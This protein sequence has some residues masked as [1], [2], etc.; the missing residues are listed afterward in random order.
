MRWH[1]LIRE[2][3]DK[4]GGNPALADE[5]PLIYVDSQRQQLHS[6]PPIGRNPIA[7]LIYIASHASC[8]SQNSE[9]CNLFHSKQ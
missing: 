5:R 7:R 3:A 1:D 6:K 8:F 9:P 4:L 2:L